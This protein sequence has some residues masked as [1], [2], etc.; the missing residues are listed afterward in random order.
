LPQDD[1]LFLVGIDWGSAEHAV[2]VVDTAG[3]KVAAF[4]VE[5]TAAGFARLTARL[6]KLGE[7]GRLPVAIE[8]P[9]GRLV[10][11]LLEAGHPVMPVKSNAIKTWPGARAVFASLSSAIALAFLTRYPRSPPPCR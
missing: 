1:A 2:C 5:H 9:D 11:A 10:D 8:R 7:A 6:G 3:R 4:T